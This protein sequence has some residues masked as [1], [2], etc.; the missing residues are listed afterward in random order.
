[1]GGAA[2]GDVGLLVKA[3]GA[4]SDGVAVVMVVAVPAVMASYTE[5]SLDC[6]KIHTG[7][8]R[9]APGGPPIASE[10]ASW[11]RRLRT[12]D[13][14]RRS[15][16]IRD[17]DLECQPR[18]RNQSMGHLPHWSYSFRSFLE[19]YP[20]FAGFWRNSSPVAESRATARAPI[21]AP[22]ARRRVL[23]NVAAFGSCKP[24]PYFD[25]HPRQKARDTMRFS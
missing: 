10:C 16:H 20:S 5:L 3:E 22:G 4:S 12:M 17:A 1:L 6:V 21:Q 25:F 14:G 11:V 24:R 13:D 23:P 15:C 2:A 8:L 7:S 19:S 9:G 18:R